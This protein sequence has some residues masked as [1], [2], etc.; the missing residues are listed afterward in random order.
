MSSKTLDPSLVPAGTPPPGVAANLIAPP[1][2]ASAVIAST[3]VT[4]SPP[5]RHSSVRKN[6]RQKWKE[7]VQ[8]FEPYKP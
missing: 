5:H 4:N 2:L 6:D 8:W 3:V 7:M 1:S